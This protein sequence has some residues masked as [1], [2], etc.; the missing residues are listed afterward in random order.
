MILA[1]EVK[2]RCEAS[3][4]EASVSCRLRIIGQCD[5]K[6]V[7]TTGSHEITTLILGM[8]TVRFK[9]NRKQ[10]ASDRTD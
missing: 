6:S 1:D 8:Q 4:R 10:T 9:M 7:Q 5:E 3:Q 2:H